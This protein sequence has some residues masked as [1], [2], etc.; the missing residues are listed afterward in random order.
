MRRSPLLFLAAALLLAT[1]LAYAGGGGGRQATYATPVKKRGRITQLR[2]STTRPRGGWR[3]LRSAWNVQRGKLAPA[4]A[5]PETTL[6]IPGHTLGY[7]SLEP[8]MKH[9]L[10][11]PAN[12]AMAAVYV[13]KSGTFRANGPKGRPMSPAEVAAAKLVTIEFSNAK[14]PAGVKG[15][16]IASA[17]RALATIKGPAHRGRVPMRVVTHSAGD[18]QFRAALLDH[19]DPGAEGIKITGQIAVGSV[20][21]GA[22]TGNAGN[23]PIGGLMGMRKAAGELAERSPFLAR[24]DASRELIDARIE[25]PRL[26][27]ALE[28]AIPLTPKIFGTPKLGRGDGFVQSADAS[29]TGARTLIMRGIDPTP[30]NHLKQIGYSGVIKAIEDELAAP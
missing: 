20:F 16:E 29:R 28:G 23:N 14:A 1:P 30:L 25:G 26:D 15:V 7:A 11:N 2:H 24:L 10:G 5:L 12:G 21:G 8:A 22:W 18:P 6:W 3:G 13:A 4:R 9:F 19:I 17:M 27:I